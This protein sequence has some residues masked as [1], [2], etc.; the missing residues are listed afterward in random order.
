M[1]IPRSLDLRIHEFI[2]DR[3]PNKNVLLVE[4]ARQVGKSSL[5]RQALDKCKRKHFSF[6]LEKETLIRSFID[7]C[8]EFKDF[9]QV[10]RDRIGFDG[11]SGQI[12]FIDEAQESRKLGRFVRFMKEEWR[13]STVILTG[14]T[15]SRLFRD[16]IRYPV[17][18]VQKITLWPF[19]FSEFLRAVGKEDVSE[20][21]CKGKTD[22]SSGHH[23]YLLELYDLF[24]ITGG[25]PEIVMAHANGKDFES[26]LDQLIADYENDFVRIFGEKDIAI[27]KSCFKSVANFV[28]SPSKNTSVIP[29]PSTPQNARIN[30]IFARLESWHLLIKAEQKGPSA[31]ANHS[32]LPKRYMFDTGILRRLRESAWPSIS[33]IRTLSSASRIPLGGAL[34]NQCAIDISR[35][36]ENVFGWKKYSSG[37]EID[38]IVKK[39]DMSVPVECKASLKFDRKHIKG[40]LD[41]MS[42]YN[43]GIGILVSLAPYQ[44]TDVPGTGKVINIP[45]YMLETL[46][47]FI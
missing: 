7:D 16:D 25:L 39:R 10:L 18:R 2:A 22:I 15:L 5:V 11:D 27:V 23:Q 36:S 4:G 14:S 44:Q 47:R 45:A 12:L 40:M 26:M 46:D 24:L 35:F 21:I 43:V 33:V 29:S 31:E 6:N 9:N 41:Y 19:S 1:Y 30:D 28:G 17:G 37:C 3:T 32:Y 34:E 38:F 42:E 13:N 20:E 8:E